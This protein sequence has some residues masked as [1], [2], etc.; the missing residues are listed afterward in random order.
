VRLR[1][2]SKAKFP[3]GAGV[4]VVMA[5]RRILYIG[6]T[7]RLRQRF[8]GHT[9][10]R[11]FTRS[12]DRVLFYPCPDLL[13]RYSVECYLLHKFWTPLNVALTGTTL[14]FRSD[15]PIHLEAS[16][17]LGIESCRKR[18]PLA[19]PPNRSSY[20]LPKKEER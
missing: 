13:E 19:L 10:S 4:Y 3:T 11:S 9:H 20:A 18:R 15:I 2:K 7:T 6:Q 14:A 17:S 5:G 16:R 1:Y 8:S 12:C